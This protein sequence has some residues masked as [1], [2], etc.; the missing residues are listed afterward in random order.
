MAALFGLNSGEVKKAVIKSSAKCYILADKSK[1]NVRRFY[2]Y[3]EFNEA[4]IIT[5]SKIEFEDGRAKIIY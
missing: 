1:F 3:G 2:T 5:D 4:T